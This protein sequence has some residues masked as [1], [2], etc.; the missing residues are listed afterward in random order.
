MSDYSQAKS[1]IT[2]LL[3]NWISAFKVKDFN[4]LRNCWDSTY[5]GLVYQAE[6]FPKPLTSWLH[7]KHYYREVLTKLIVRVT[8]WDRNGIWINVFGDV[9]YAYSTNDFTMIV[10]NLPEAYSGN[11]RQTFVVRKVDGAWKIIHY[12]E[13][14]QS[15][16]TPEELRLDE[17]DPK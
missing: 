9:G 7:I 10:H 13:S 16:P 4:T 14:L 1:E 15:M 17:P 5:D 6:E 11:V 12:H 8:K 3:D 2:A